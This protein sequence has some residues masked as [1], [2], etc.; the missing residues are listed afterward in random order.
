V[1]PGITTTAGGA[2]LYFCVCAPPRHSFF[3]VLSPD[4]DDFSVQFF[5]VASL[6]IGNAH[7]IYIN[8]DTKVAYAVGSDTCSGGLHMIN[9]AN[10]ASPQFLA[11]YAN[12]GYTHDVQCTLK[13]E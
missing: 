3:F 13:N 4:G 1:S 2:L 6:I 8:E 11:C 9:V 10:P 7:N 5:S 12:D